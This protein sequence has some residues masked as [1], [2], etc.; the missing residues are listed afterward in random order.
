[1]YLVDCCGMFSPG[2]QVHGDD[3]CSILQQSYFLPQFSV[4]KGIE[5]GGWFG[6]GIDEDGDLISR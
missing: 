1:M 5:G 6:S 3:S 2:K 4:G